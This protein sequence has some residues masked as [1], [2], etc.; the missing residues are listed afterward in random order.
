MGGWLIHSFAFRPRKPV[1]TRPADLSPRAKGVRFAATDGLLLSGFLAPPTEDRPVVIVNHGIGGNRDEIM[2]AARVLAASGYGVLTYD[3]RSH[4]LSQG[5]MTTFGVEES[6]DLAGALDYLASLPETRNRP[7]AVLSVSLGASASASA[8]ASFKGRVQCMVLDSPF[9]RLDRMVA[10][11]VGHL[12]PLAW[13]VGS[14]MDLF[15]RLAIGKSLREISPE[16]DLKAFAPHPV[17]VFHGAA[18]D[19]IPVAESESLLAA[20]PGP[21]QHWVTEGDGHLE[22]HLKRAT[23]WM[24]RVALFLELHLDGAPPA[25]LVLGNMPAGVS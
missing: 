3:W 2:G 23:E 15:S 13:G 11:K 12:G 5:S 4:G 24:R 1:L 25:N 19:L 7:V 6:R 8:V 16:R 20:Y 14:S 9:G 22:A 10:D 17:L 21:H 18:D